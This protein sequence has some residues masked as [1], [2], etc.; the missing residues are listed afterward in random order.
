MTPSEALTVLARQAALSAHP[1]RGG[2]NDA[3]RRV[4]EA[5][6]VL[7]KHHTPAPARPPLPRMVACRRWHCPEAIGPERLETI[8]WGKHEG[9]SWMDAP[10]SYLC[11]LAETSY[12][13]ETRHKALHFLHLRVREMES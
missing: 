1:D 5:R 3:M 2:S 9:E 8:P 10:L 11:W 12:Q 7:T 13:A 4:N 6:E